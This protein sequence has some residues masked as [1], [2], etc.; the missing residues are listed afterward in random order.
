MVKVST[1]VTKWDDSAPILHNRVDVAVD[2]TEEQIPMSLETNC[3]SY[4]SQE[5]QICEKM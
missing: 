5:V 4:I 3:E 1:T 2:N